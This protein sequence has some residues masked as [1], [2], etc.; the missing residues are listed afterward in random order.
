M[1]V[2][3]RFNQRVLRAHQI[4]VGMSE[5]VPIIRTSGLVRTRVADVCRWAIVVLSDWARAADL[6]PTFTGGRPCN[7]TRTAEDLSLQ[8]LE[9]STAQ[10]DHTTEES[11]GRIGK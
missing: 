10:I 7:D 11:L 5:G 3:F 1:E 9:V 4:I 8:P 6:D 2:G